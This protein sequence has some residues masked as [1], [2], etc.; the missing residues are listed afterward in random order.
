MAS[1]LKVSELPSSSTLSQ[2]DLFLVADVTNQ[3]SKSVSFATLNSRLSFS[4]LIG[5]DQYLSDLQSVN[6]LITDS[7]SD[8][9][10]SVNG[11]LGDLQNLIDALDVKTTAS[12][13]NN[14][15]RIDNLLT[16]L[17]E[18]E[19]LRFRAGLATGYLYAQNVNVGEV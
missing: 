1:S 7:V 12:A 15:S 19:D 18:L 5:Y 2:T 14:S 6:T 9:S 16:K 3:V 4:D 11:S 17:E 13:S 10:D 8:L